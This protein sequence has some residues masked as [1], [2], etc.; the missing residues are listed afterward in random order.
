MTISID[1]NIH[2]VDEWARLLSIHD[3]DGL[4]QLF[5]DDVVYEDVALGVV[6]RGQDALRTFASRFITAFPDVT[7]ELS[8]RF[9]T[10]TQA[11]AEWVMRGTQTGDLPER[12]ATGRRI[13]VRGASI[14]EFANGKIR[15]VADYW[16]RATYL[17]QRQ[18]SS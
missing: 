10:P 17:D 1:S 16:D 12:A 7:L 14:L 4:V 5:S 3:L 18:G 11:G 9:A 8:T 6:N 13:D 2:L 15:R